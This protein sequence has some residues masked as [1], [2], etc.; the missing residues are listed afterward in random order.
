MSFHLQI[1][2][3]QPAP[4]LAV[5]LPPLKVSLP[6][7][8]PPPVSVLLADQWLP[9]PLQATQ[10]TS[11]SVSDHIKAYPTP[12]QRKKTPDCLEARST[13][14]SKTSPTAAACTS[15]VS[16]DASTLHG[17]ARHRLPSPC[18]LPS[19]SFNVSFCRQHG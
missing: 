13:L 6:V 19:G 2:C 3:L 11:V 16:S 10:T 18:S 5:Q 14:C 1:S 7:T 17:L 8:Q 4:P 9:G 12:G 15:Q